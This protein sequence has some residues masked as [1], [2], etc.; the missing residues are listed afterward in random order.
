MVLVAGAGGASAWAKERE[1]RGSTWVR[2]VARARCPP[3]SLLVNACSVFYVLQ[4]ECGVF[5]PRFRNSAGDGELPARTRH[6]HTGTAAAVLYVRSTK[7]SGLAVLMLALCLWF[8]FF[9]QD[10]EPSRR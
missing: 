4:L 3:C 8:C 9:F 1:H 2:A 5:V 10:F 6:V 7:P